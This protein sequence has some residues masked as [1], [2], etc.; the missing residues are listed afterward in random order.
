MTSW[1]W[2]SVASWSFTMI[3]SYM[4]HFGISFLINFDLQTGFIWSALILSLVT[5]F[6]ITCLTICCYILSITSLSC[7]FLIQ[8]TWYCIILAP[9]KIVVAKMVLLF[10]GC[11]P[12]IIDYKILYLKRASCWS[13]SLAN[14]LGAVF[15]TVLHVV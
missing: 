15:V 9:T 10:Y 3:Y 7:W 14:E 12:G 4:S 1:N 5:S 13:I 2:V 11:F 6:R 8:P